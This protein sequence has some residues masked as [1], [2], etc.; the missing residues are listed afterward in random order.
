MNN[1]HLFE[2]INASPG[3]DPVHLLLAMFLAQWVI[4]LVALA[5]AVAWVRGDHASR[6]ELLQML[7]ATLIALLIAHTWPQ[8]RPFA[9][10]LGTQYLAHGNDP[11]LPSDH[12]T[13]L[14][15]LAL[16][17]LGTRRYPVW[18]FPLLALGL[19][20]G[21]SRVYLGVHFPFDI[22]AAL[23]V[24]VAGALAERALRGPLLPI[25]ERILNH[26]DRFTLALRAMLHGSNKA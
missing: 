5:L 1:V 23:P 25:S 10:H 16:A 8:P 11:G 15:A 21:L 7:T 2:L 24:A 14:W 22:A 20:V 6:G 19:V 13:A 9:L 26:Y 3:L 17:A 18:G 4:Y 12:A